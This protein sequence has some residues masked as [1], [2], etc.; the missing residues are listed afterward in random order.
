[1]NSAQS[2][3]SIVLSDDLREYSAGDWTG[4]SR[5]ATLTQEVVHRMTALGQTFQPPGGESMNQVERR[6]SAWLEDNL[7][8]NIDFHTRCSNRPHRTKVAIFSHGLTIKCLMHYIMGFDQL[9]TWKISV[10]NTSISHFT[11]KDAWFVN[12]IN[13][14]PHLS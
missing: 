12:A 6:A 4:A 13:N 11:F 14:C 7:M 5:K 1:M 3:I 10:D 2:N 8:Y 9:L